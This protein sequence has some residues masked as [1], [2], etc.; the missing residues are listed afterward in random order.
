MR[1]GTFQTNNSCRVKLSNYS[2]F[3]LIF[4]GLLFKWLNNVPVLRTKWTSLILWK[5]N[6]NCPTV[7]TFASSR[8]LS[9]F[10]THVYWRFLLILDDL[11]YRLLL[12]QPPACSTLSFALEPRSTLRY[13]FL[14][15]MCVLGH[16]SLSGAWYLGL[17]GM[18]WPS[19]PS[20]RKGAILH[21]LNYQQLL[22]LQVL[23]T[24]SKESLPHACSIMCALDL[25][26]TIH[27]SNECHRAIDS[28]GNASVT[29]GFLL[30]K[31]NTSQL[32]IQGC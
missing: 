25:T 17:P 14:H 8:W 13:F 6:G 19:L 31:K 7:S 20:V 9:S 26:R 23:S 21:L 11:C 24:G 2:E 18:S 30:W 5:L 3:R 22:M 1:S 12:L 10:Y 32:L 4:V 15:Q 16:K 29:S 28:S 27:R